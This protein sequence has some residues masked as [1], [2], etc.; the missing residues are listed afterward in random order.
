MSRTRPTS[1]R[2]TTPDGQQ[3]DR[4]H[5]PGQ[6]RTGTP[7]HPVAGITSI[8]SAMNTTVTPAVRITRLHSYSTG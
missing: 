2:W 1:P 7:T 8:D 5:H 6:I 3:A 4:E